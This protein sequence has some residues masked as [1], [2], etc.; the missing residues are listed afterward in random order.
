MGTLSDV[1]SKLEELKLEL[2]EYK[3]QDELTKIQSMNENFKFVMEYC[4]S[5]GYNSICMYTKIPKIAFQYFNEKLEMKPPIYGNPN[6]YDGRH[7]PKMFDGSFYHFGYNY[8]EALNQM[9]KIFPDRII[10]IKILGYG[11]Y[12][13]YN[14]FSYNYPAKFE[15]Y[16]M[17]KPKTENIIEI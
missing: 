15:V 13:N 3:K 11:I 10:L 6:D 4:H 9:E 5:A 12:S 1:L 2:L 8:T 14:G 17:F 7:G 16:V